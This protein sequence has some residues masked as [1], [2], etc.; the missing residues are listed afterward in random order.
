M[1][2]HLNTNFLGVKNR[3]TVKKSIPFTDAAVTKLSAKYTSKN[4][5][6]K[7]ILSRVA[8]Y[9]GSNSEHAQRLY[10]YMS[11]FWFMPSSP[12]LTNGGTNRG[13]P[14]SCFIN[15]AEDSIESIS[16]TWYEN[17]WL[18]TN[19]GG[20]ATYW[21]NVRSAGQKITNKGTTSG[22]MP[23]IQVQ[24][25][26][27]L[28][29]SQGS[30]RGGS[31]AIYVDMVHPEVKSIF[32]MRAPVGGDPGLKA[33]N[34]H[35]GICI[36]D[37]FMQKVKEDGEWNLIDPHTKEITETGKA[38]DYWSN[39]LGM[40]L[41]TGEPY[42]FFTD[43]VNR[44]KP[45]SYKRH[46]LKVKSSNLCSE[47]M[48]ATGKDHLGNNRT[49]VCCLAS[50]NLK[51][52]DKWKGSSIVYD[53][54]EMLDNVLIDFTNKAPSKLKD[55]VYSVHR[56]RSVGL[57]VM[58]FHTLLQ[59]KSLCMGTPQSM[60]LTKEIFS[61]IK[62]KSD[63]MS[64]LL[65]EERGSYLD[66]Q[67]LEPLSTQMKRFT[68]M[69]AIAPTATIST[70]CGGVSPGI[71]PISGNIFIHSTNT[72]DTTIKN[73]SLIPVLKSYDKDNLETWM[74]IAANNGSVQHLDFLN[75]K[76]K[77]VFKTAYEI[78]QRDIIDL[79]AL[80]QHYVCQSQSLNLFFDREPARKY[81]H[82]V[83]LN[84]FDMGIKS[85]YYVRC[86][87]KD[88]YQKG[89]GETGETCSMCQ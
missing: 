1:N 73:A 31:A 71:D 67:E 32:N 36:T 74:S 57:G 47:I 76:E 62:E 55:A 9:Y 78:D 40:R 83:H 33:L 50:L 81:V 25:A 11:D 37:E 87:E 13:M 34:L 38:R 28:A 56:E 53:V 27:T 80:R 85:L 60:E 59:D 77:A 21:G 58:G 89:D 66:L 46:D 54:L 4:E 19:G 49:A 12:I 35:H 61:Y 72:G 14:I 24:N 48:L 82:E 68:H 23:Y 5:Q 75:C 17:I 88:V 3:I 2:Q 63:Y 15:E 22:I 44:N 29:I 84:A 39:L 45:E 79:A 52:Y 6:P 30:L 70:I 65:G 86:S 69:I 26:L 20:I 42:I 51:Y 64:E 41:E 7:D 43:T 10:D 8:T 18:A 16:D